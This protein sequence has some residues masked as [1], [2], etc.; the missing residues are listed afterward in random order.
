MS[1]PFV[2][3]GNLAYAVARVH[4]HVFDLVVREMKNTGVEAETLAARLRL[5][6]EDIRHRLRRP[7]RISIE[8]ASQIMWALSGASIILQPERKQ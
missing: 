5:P 7:G 6:V 8:E 1:E 3:S 2:S 4:L